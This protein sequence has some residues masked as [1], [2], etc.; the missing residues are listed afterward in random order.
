MRSRPARQAMSK[1]PCARCKSLLG[2]ESIATTER[3]TAVDDSEI[4]AAMGAGAWPLAGCQ[5][6]PQTL[7]AARTPG[8]HGGGAGR[9]RRR[10]GVEAEQAAHCLVTALRAGGRSSPTGNSRNAWSPRSVIYMLGLRT[11]VLRD[12]MRQGHVVRNVVKLVDRIPA[13]PKLPN[14]FTPAELQKVFD[15]IDGGRYAIAWQ[16]ALTGLRGGEVAGL[17][18]SDVDL[19]T[20]TLPILSSDCQ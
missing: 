9:A 3:Y 1:Q 10:R 8:E 7:D 11:A 17:R 2:R 12:Q 20:R 15:H 18:W 16:L 4:R 13:D 5:T 6:W 14:T 19:D